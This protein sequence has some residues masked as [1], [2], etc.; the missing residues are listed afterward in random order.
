MKKNVNYVQ[1]ALVIALAQ[2]M[3]L[4]IEPQKGFTK[5]TGVVP[6]RAV[7]PANSKMIGRIDLSGFTHVAGATHPSP[8]TKRVQQCVDMSKPAPEILRDLYNILKDALVDDSANAQSIDSSAKKVVELTEEEI[9]TQL[10]ALLA[11]VG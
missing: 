2:K 10:D 11:D 5:I 4:S 7:Y 1:Q 3:G 9:N 8:P 6:N